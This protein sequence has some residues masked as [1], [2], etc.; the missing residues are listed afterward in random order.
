MRN[1]RP[2]S[3]RWIEAAADDLDF[4]F[5]ADAVGQ[6]GDSVLAQD[7]ADFGAVAGLV[8]L[9]AE[10]A[11]IEAVLAALDAPV[12]PVISLPVAAP[13]ELGEVA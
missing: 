9:Y 11:E 12:A 5:F 3:R 2:N 13:R 10:M 7:F 6:A 4:D 1:V 8:D